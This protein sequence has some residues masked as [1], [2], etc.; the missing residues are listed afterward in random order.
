VANLK[1]QK[2][3]GILNQSSSYQLL[4]STKASQA[5]AQLLG[6][7]LDL[8]YMQVFCQSNMISNI[9]TK[10]FIQVHCSLDIAVLT[11]N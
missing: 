3:T 11:D 6:R 8:T 9:L 4:S 2:Y 1:N 10:M 7:I 5:V